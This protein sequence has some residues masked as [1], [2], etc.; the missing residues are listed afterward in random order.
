MPENTLA[1]FDLDG[2]ITRHD[3]LWPFISG[4]LR[5]HPARWWRLAPCLAPLTRYLCGSRDRGALKGAIIRWTLGGVSRA[6]LAQWSTEFAARLLRDGL[7]AEAL[8]CIEVHRRAHTHLVLLSASPDLYVPAI[9]QA[10]GFDECVCTEV[11]W[12]SDGTPGGQPGLRQPARPG[13]GALRAGTAGRAPTG[14][15]NAYGNSP[16]DLEHLRLVSSGT[17]VNGS[18]RELAGMPNVRAV[19]WS[20]PAHELLALW[21]NKRRGS[22]FGPV[23]RAQPRTRARQGRPSGLHRGSRFP[24]F[25]EQPEAQAPWPDRTRPAVPPVPGL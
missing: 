10:L 18:A 24:Q 5:R 17:Y 14:Y 16:A 6:A 9:A 22:G 3:T 11:R 8:A 1:I 25:R 13:E 15:S 7:Y 2:T 20:V 4:F 12:R 19:R 23:A 21:P